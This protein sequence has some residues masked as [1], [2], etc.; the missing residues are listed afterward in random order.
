L[1]LREL[2]QFVKVFLEYD[3]HLLDPESTIRPDQGQDTFAQVRKQHSVANEGAFSSKFADDADCLA[4]A[5]DKTAK[6]NARME[7]KRASMNSALLDTVGLPP[8]EEVVED[9][10]SDEFDAEEDFKKN[11]LKQSNS[12]RGKKRVSNGGVLVAKRKSKAAVPGPLVETPEDA[13]MGTKAFSMCL[14][15]SVHTTR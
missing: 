2:K 12:L 6:D 5:A 13:D 11:G 15:H 7:A 1:L 14:I 10:Q 9:E 4:R 3:E 8:K